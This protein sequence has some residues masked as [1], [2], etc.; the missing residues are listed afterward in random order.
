MN[1]IRRIYLKTTR[2]KLHKPFS[3]LGLKR[4]EKFLVSTPVKIKDFLKILPF[5]GGIR[6]LG[7]VIL[8]VPQSFA[9]FIRIL[10]AKVF[11]A[12]YWSNVPE[13]LTREFNF[14]KKELEVYNCSWLIELNE[15]AN[16]ALPSLI[17]A[18]RRVAFYNDR[19]FPYYNILVKGG[20]ESLAN[21]FQIS[22]VEPE[23]MFKFNKL[24]LRSILKNL[25]GQPPFLFVNASGKKQFVKP[26]TF[27]WQ[28]SMVVANKSKDDVESMCKKLYLCNAYYGPDDEFCELGRIFKKNIIIP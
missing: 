13:V 16:I 17:N 22:V 8:F 1:I 25:D 28:G 20:I 10:K 5:L 15:N 7:E 18:E 26:E 23:T 6:N 9:P 2:Y 3:P 19:N 4:K 24:E 14:L 21:F 27:E 11:Q 12:I